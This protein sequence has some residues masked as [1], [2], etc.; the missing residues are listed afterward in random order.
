MSHL[1][2][3][4]PQVPSWRGRRPP[5]AGAR[6]PARP[7]PSSSGAWGRGP[8][9]KASHVPLRHYLTCT[10]RATYALQG[11][12]S[13]APAREEAEWVFRPRAVRVH[14]PEKLG[15]MQQGLIDQADGFCGVRQGGCTDSGVARQ[16]HEVRCAPQASR[17]GGTGTGHAGGL[18]LHHPGLKRPRSPAGNRDGEAAARALSDLGCMARRTRAW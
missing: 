2:I 9:A 17:W 15:A 3:Q 5:H 10:L 7:R 8:C 14:R 4:G 12:V 18:V 1:Y 16:C 13:M 11:P 6:S